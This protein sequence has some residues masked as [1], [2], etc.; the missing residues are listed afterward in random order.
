[1]S[2]LDWRWAS[3][4]VRGMRRMDVGV[5]AVMCAG[6]GRSLIRDRQVRLFAACTGRAVV[7]GGRGM[8]GC[9]YGLLGIAA[10]SRPMD[11]G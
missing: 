5:V 1:C 8:C 3:V 11:C 6:G 7:C 2:R 4:V 9:F 10:G